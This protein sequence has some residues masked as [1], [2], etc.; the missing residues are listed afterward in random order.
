MMLLQLAAALKSSRG[1]AHKRDIGDV[2]GT[3]AAQ[4]PG[5]LAGLSHSVT[6][7]DDCAVITDSDG[8]HLLLAIEGLVEDFIERM[9]WFA[10]Y[11]SVMVNVSDVYAM[12]GEP[13]AVVDALW[14]RGMDPAGKML[15]GMAAASLR[16]GVPIV[17]GHSNNRSE[18]GQLAVAILGRARHLLTS[19]AARPGDRLVVAVDLRGAYREPYPYWDASTAAPALRLRADLAILPTLAERGFCRAAKDISMAGAIGTALMLTESSRVAASIDVEAIPRPPGVP[20]ER[21]LLTFPSYGFVLSVR[22]EAVDPVLAT[23]RERE[24][25]CAVVGEVEEGSA[26]WIRDRSDECLLW[27]WAE[28][29]FIRAAGAEQ[30]RAGLPRAEQVPV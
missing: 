22:P 12:G 20:L 30:H 14:S 26:L 10:G 29:A 11:C 7:G 6:S 18:R 19:D 4:L 16:Y 17:G 3:L 24:L 25:A 27:D 15:E 8:S 23:F 2:V 21:W 1:F 9:P 28:T 13:I 5:G